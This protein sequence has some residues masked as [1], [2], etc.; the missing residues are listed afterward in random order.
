MEELVL[1]QRSLSR[2]TENES[3][4]VI[5]VLTRFNV[6]LILKRKAVLALDCLVR[7]R[8]YQLICNIEKGPS[9]EIL[10]VIKPEV[11][12]RI[13]NKTPQ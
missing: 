12:G 11:E 4:P 3:V 9:K 13:N 5:K 7:L 6:D 10:P 8:K 2:S 1:G